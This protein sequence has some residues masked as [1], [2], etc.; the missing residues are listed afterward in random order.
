VPGLARAGAAL[1]IQNFFLEVHP[2]PDIAPSDGPNMLRLDDFEQVVAD[3]IA[4]NK[5]VAV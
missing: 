2:N 3:I 5:V 4:I 1:G